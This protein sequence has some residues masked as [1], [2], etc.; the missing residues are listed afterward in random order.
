MATT[1]R[2]IRDQ[3]LDRET[4]RRFP[5]GG[6]DAAQWRNTQFAPALD[7]LVRTDGMGVERHAGHYVVT[8]PNSNG[9]AFGSRCSA[10][11][12]L[13]GRLVRVDYESVEQAAMDW[14]TW[15]TAEEAEEAL[16]A[17][18]AAEVQA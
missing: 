11:A 10:L 8:G 7:S 5:R 2:S 4:A 14:E 17:W 9:R 15:R 6:I 12:R 16:W 1:E 3:I 18:R 13:R